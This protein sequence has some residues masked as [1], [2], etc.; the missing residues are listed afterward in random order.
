MFQMA[1]FFPPVVWN[2]FSLGRFLLPKYQLG[3][4]FVSGD[5]V[6]VNDGYVLLYVAS[7]DH[8]S[9]SPAFV[10]D[11]R[12]GLI[13]DAGNGLSKDGHAVR[14]IGGLELVTRQWGRTPS[15]VAY[16]SPVHFL[17]TA[18]DVFA[19]LCSL[20]DRIKR[21]LEAD[22]GDV[23]GELPYEDVYEGVDPLR[24][25]DSSLMFDFSRNEM[26]ERILKLNPE[27]G[28][29]AVRPWMDMVGEMDTYD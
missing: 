19:C 13:Y 6:E 2:E 7:S 4:G 16:V 14:T 18:L 27:T 22:F 12:T 5:H 20:N 3:S 29:A 26:I 10:L 17:A 9:W 28:M 25:S 11:Q 21:W 23:Q 1:D 24:V 15:A 8:E